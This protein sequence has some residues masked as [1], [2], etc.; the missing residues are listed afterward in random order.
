MLGGWVPQST[1]ACF[2]SSPSPHTQ[3]LGAAHQV[4]VPLRLHQTFLQRKLDVGTCCKMI[5][6][7]P[8]RSACLYSSIILHTRCARTLFTT[9]RCL[10]TC[11][12][13]L[14]ASNA[15][16]TIIL[17]HTAHPM[18][19]DI[20]HVERLGQV[21]MAP[22]ALTRSLIRDMLLHVD[23]SNTVLV[24]TIVGGCSIWR[25]SRA[26]LHIAVPFINSTVLLPHTVVHPFD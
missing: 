6:P 1:S 26:A 8:P 12:L 11:C 5:L 20:V 4:G 21:G 19:P 23:H 14:C 15:L 2:G 7:M 3:G 25:V 9:I 10:N 17:H 13:G 16:S 24:L 22:E 18:W